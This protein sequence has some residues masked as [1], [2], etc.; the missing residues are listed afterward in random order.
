M[1]IMTMRMIARSSAKSW[2]QQVRKLCCQYGLQDPAHLLDSPAL[3]EEFKLEAKK[4]ITE[5]WHCEL[6]TEVRKLKSLTYFKPELY[7]LTK[8]HSMWNTALSNPFEC[9]K[10]QT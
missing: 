7:S 9:S 6:A 10:S 4:K 5:Y 1:V 2:F 3:K 8:P